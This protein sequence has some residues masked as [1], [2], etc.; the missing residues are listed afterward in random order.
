MVA[1][2]ISLEKFKAVSEMYREKRNFM[3]DMLIFD[4]SFQN[5]LKRGFLYLVKKTNSIRFRHNWMI[6]AVFNNDSE[7]SLHGGAVLLEVI[8]HFRY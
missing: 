8:V 3:T 5:F 1:L 2:Y 7:R 6:D 4:L